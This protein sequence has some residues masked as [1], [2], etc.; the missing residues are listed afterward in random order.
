M[1]DRD[2]Y[3]HFHSDEHHFVDKALDWLERAGERHT[4]KLSD[5]LDPR[6]A[7]ILTML[8]N[9]HSDAQVQLFG[10]YVGAERKRAWIAPEYKAP[11][12]A[13]FQLSLLAI[14]SE[15]PQFGSLE[16]GDFLGALLGVGLKRDRIGDLHVKERQCHVVLATE[17]SDFF[18]MQLQ[19]VGRAHVRTELL[20]ISALE[21][22]VQ[23]YEEMGLSVA[24]MRM[25]GIVSDVYRLSRAK[26]LPPIKNGRCR[27]NWKVEE[28][29]SKS[30]KAGDVVSFQGF[31]RFRVLDV[32]GETKKGRIRLK[33]GKYV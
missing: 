12:E 10:G 15:D 21:P 9:R 32:E 33:I 2:F 19:Q 27:I 22:V 4:V 24:S 3:S 30:L 17:V 7:H 14:T 29:P 23:S 31:G 20:P 25:D 26:V 16:H 5:F 28:D 13:D 8:A 6:Q 11:Q 18:R 1:T